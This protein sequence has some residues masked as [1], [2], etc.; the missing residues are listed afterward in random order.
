MKIAYG[1][2]YRQKKAIS[3]I[4][5][6]I[7]MFAMLFTVLFG[8]LIFNSQTTLT[9]NQANAQRQAAIQQASAENLILGA[10]FKS[11]P[12]PWGQIGDLWLTINNTGNAVVTIADVYVTK[13]ADGSFLSNSVI[14]PSNSH[15][16]TSKSSTQ[17]GDLNINLPLTVPMG[18][19]TIRMTGCSGDPYGCDI[20]ISQQAYNY[21]PGTPVEVNVVTSSGNV[22]SV[23]YPPSTQQQSGFATNPLVLSMVATPPQTL[24]CTAPNCITLS[25]TV[26]NYATSPVSNVNLN[27]NPPSAQYTGTATVY[28]GSCTGPFVNGLPS[29]TIPSYTGGNPSSATFSCS[30]SAS[31]GQVGGFASFSARATGTLNGMAVSSAQE[32]SN[33]VQIGGTV[34]VLNQGPFS[35]NSF[36]FKDTY[37]YQP[38][39]TTPTFWVSPCTQ[40]PSG[41]LP[42][43]GGLSSLPNANNAP[44]N[45]ASSDYYVA[46]YLQVTNNFNTTI[47]VLQYSYFQT[48]P[49]LGGESDFYIAGSTSAYN[50]GA[51][52]PNYATLTPTLTAYGGSAL[53]CESNPSNC[54][55]V[56]PGQTITLTFAACKA[57][58]TDWNW[59]DS[60]YGKAFDDPVG[61]S[62][63]SPPNYQTP[64]ATYLSVII[65]F[66][67]KSQVYDQ[68]IPFQGEV[69]FGGNNPP[70][71]CAEGK[72]CG[73]VFYTQYGNYL[74]GTG[75]S[76][77][78][79]GAVGYFNF[80]YSPGTTT[81]AVNIPVVI[82]NYLPYGVDG[83]NFD[84]QDHLIITGTN[85]C[86][87]SNGNPENP[88]FNEVNPNTGAVTTYST[89]ASS[90]NVNVNYNGTI[91]YADS[92]GECPNPTAAT[93]PPGI[94]TNRLTYIKLPPNGQTAQT[95]PL[96]GDDLYLNSLMIVD[97]T[98]AY[99]T[100]QC[101]IS[102]NPT[103][104]AA[105][106][107]GQYGHVGTI[108]LATGKTTCFGPSPGVCTIFDGVH[109]GIYDPFT[110]D[111]M[112]FG[113]N[114]INQ[115]NPTTGLLVA[116][117]SV[118]NGNC[119]P[120]PNNNPCLPNPPS[121]GNVFDQ[122][123]VDGFGHLF[124]S[125]AA[126]DGGVYFEDYAANGLI[127][128]F[129]NPLPA[130]CKTTNYQTFVGGPGFLNNLGQPAFYDIDDM[131][132]IVGPGSQ[133]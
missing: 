79:Y 118:P 27:P 17:S 71:A 97:S 110:G 131:A 57:G 92:D 5:A 90:Y 54:I 37:C 86:C 80:V 4:L 122:G 100:A 50:S 22:F 132:P 81:L 14:P 10:G 3:S 102:G 103:C 65:S 104:T 113:W 64:E 55:N 76:S 23:R 82:K 89:T 68:Q 40:T 84:P 11:A 78:N 127:G 24:S 47:Q 46:Y 31:T 85:Y 33:S 114:E 32:V 9:N 121:G 12:D 96:S 128:C 125:W 61:C 36:F 83:V 38:G 39:T 49:T 101:P 94:C 2:K 69:V 63:E 99:Y 15:Y 8:F 116:Q 106:Y 67:Y 1:G 60:Q 73:T 123:A 52:F 48:D 34:S 111:L 70:K 35:A 126:D 87:D 53:T 66:L 107:E 6:S 28:G 77:T 18:A 130:G 112:V 44:N 13:I 30:Y 21:A 62:P 58:S 124:L 20:A 109:G 117:E 88:Y 41:T 120:P 25:V 91:V 108:N 74:C 59:G 51:Y 133:G 26:Y 29:S 75:C 115:I 98:H 105:R 95:L 45:N 43:A 16:L 72:Y 19:S 129:G 93:T 56:A 119:P 42:P 7:L